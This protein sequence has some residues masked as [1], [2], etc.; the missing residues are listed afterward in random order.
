MA[1]PPSFL[2]SMGVIATLVAVTITLSLAWQL[3]Q[4][5]DASGRPSQYDPGVSLSAAAKTAQTPLLIEFYSDDCGAC[6]QLTPL[7]HRVATTAFARRLKLVMINV[8]RPQSQ[9]AAA[10]FR[11]DSV[12]SV[13]VFDPKRMKK[14]TIPFAALSN[15]R[16]LEAALNS[17]LAGLGAQ[18]QSGSAR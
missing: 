15:P 5:A 14:K 4:G 9:D 7:V 10:L 3:F 8:D 12:P 13:F 17:A 16:R 18:G 2:R 6:V 11:V 1:A